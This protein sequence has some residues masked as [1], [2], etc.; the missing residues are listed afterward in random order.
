[1]VRR[2]NEPDKEYSVQWRS[3]VKLEMFE[4]L[5]LN[6]ANELV[7][8]ERFEDAYDYFT[9]LER[10]KS[11]T[12]G[13]S[14]SFENSLYEEAKYCHRKKQFDGALAL[15]R[16]MHLRNPRRPGL[17]V[18]FGRTTDELVKRYVDEQ[19]YDA[20]RALLRNLSSDYSDHP[21]VLQ[22]RDRLTKQA[23]PLLAEARAAADAGQWAKAGELTRRI[24]DIWPEL[25]GARDL[26]ETVHK[27]CPRVVVGVG[28]L[29]T[30][31]VAEP[32]RRLVHPAH[33]PAPLPNACRVCRGQHRR[34]EVRLPGR[35]NF[36]AIPQPPVG[37]SLET[38]HR[39]G[40]RQCH[41]EQLR[42]GAAALGHGQSGRPRLSRR[43]G[44]SLAGGFD[45][46]R[47]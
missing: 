13:L 22:W 10:N 37:D 11:D 32:S 20:A 45:Q 15:L 38:R 16:E 8:D 41:A 34:R 33:Q 6:K 26:A 29:A 36:P 3:I 25:P 9:Y 47:L 46:R 12:P 2:L 39:L 24:A 7:A 43:L 5:I 42:R 18:A 14:R 35:R 27:E 21:V 31:V 19:N 1:M 4:Q 23:T 28:S 40:Q 44:R 17:D 30:D